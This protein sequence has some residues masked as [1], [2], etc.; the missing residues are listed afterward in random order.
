MTD[1]TALDTD[2]VFK[3]AALIDRLYF[4]GHA[5]TVQGHDVK[6]V[7]RKHVA[8]AHTYQTGNLSVEVATGKGA[9]NVSRPLYL[10]T[11]DD[12]RGIITVDGD[13][14]IDDDGDLDP[15][16]APAVKGNADRPHTSHSD[17]D[18]EPTKAARAKC[19]R[20]RAKAAQADA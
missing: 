17:C 14:L 18:H 7:D 11:G 19:R 20:A 15:R 8:P 5:L 10:K 6:T 16:F 1:Y 3:L 12:L 13:V 2:N 9:K 4:K